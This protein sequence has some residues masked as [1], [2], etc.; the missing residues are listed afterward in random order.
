MLFDTRLRSGFLFDTRL[1][2]GIL[3]ALTDVMLLHVVVA[4]N[5][6]VPCILSGPLLVHFIPGLDQIV[7]DTA[8]YMKLKSAVGVVTLYQV[9]LIRFN[10][11]KV[12]E[13]SFL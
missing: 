10:L 11:A 7:L 8:S 4:I 3:R 12:A 1:R 13:K 5:K 6:A 2:I 9:S